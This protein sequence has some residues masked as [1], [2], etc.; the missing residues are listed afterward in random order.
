MQEQ[1]LRSKAST[2]RFPNKWKAIAFSA[3]GLAFFLTGVI[4]AL[5]HLHQ[6]AQADTSSDWPTYMANNQ[7]SG[8]NGAETIINATSAPNLKVHWTAKGGGMV[9]SQP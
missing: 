1:A 2:G 3:L 9:F 4:T 5:P 6:A 7:R 8:F